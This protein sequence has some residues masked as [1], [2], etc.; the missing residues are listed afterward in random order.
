MTK[1]PVLCSMHVSVRSGGNARSSLKLNV[2]HK[3]CAPVSDG[4][5]RTWCGLHLLL[6]LKGLVARRVAARPWPWQR[7]WPWPLIDLSSRLARVAT[8]TKPT[9]RERCSTFS[10]DHSNRLRLRP[11]PVLDAK[12]GRPR[13]INHT[14][15]HRFRE[16]GPADRHIDPGPVCRRL[17]WHGVVD[18]HHLAPV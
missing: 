7:E 2:T 16:A 10:V 18:D 1:S 6:A 14:N 12:L 17:L 8:P 11:A 9:A 4:R 5:C 3:P 13:I 15:R